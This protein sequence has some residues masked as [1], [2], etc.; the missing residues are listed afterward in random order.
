[1][2]GYEAQFIQIAPFSATGISATKLHKKN[3]LKAAKLKAAHK[4]FRA[5]CL[6][7]LRRYC[8]YSSLAD[9]AADV[10]LIFGS[11]KE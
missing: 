1:M 3:V 5:D 11:S 8:G 9:E 4:I 6:G 10:P 7:S 2:T